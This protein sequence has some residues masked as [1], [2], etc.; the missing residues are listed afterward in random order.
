MPRSGLAG[1]V[2]SRPAASSSGMT[3]FQLEASAKAPCTST[4]VGEASSDMRTP[5]RVSL[6]EIEE[7]LAFLDDEG[8][9]LGGVAGADVPNR[10]HGLG[11]HGQGVARAHLQRRLPV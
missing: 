2:T 10:V 7:R 6:G 5:F 9:E 1:A 11:R 3:P 8:R 4:I